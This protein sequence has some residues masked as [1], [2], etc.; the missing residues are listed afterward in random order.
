MFEDKRL[1]FMYWVV[2]GFVKLKKRK[3]NMCPKINKR[4]LL[5]KILFV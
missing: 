1:E 2:H 4:F 3:E 5:R